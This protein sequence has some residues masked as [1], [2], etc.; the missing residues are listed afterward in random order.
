MCRELDQLITSYFFRFKTRQTRSAVMPPKKPVAA[1][2]RGS[3]AP[4]KASAPRVPGPTAAAK[5]APG[6]AGPSKTGKASAPGPSELM[7][8]NT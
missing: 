4:A 6:G 8:V 2:G 7:S 3:K 5:K 1:A